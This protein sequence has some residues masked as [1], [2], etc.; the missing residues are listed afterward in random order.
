MRVRLAECDAVMLSADTAENRHRRAHS[1]KQL[2]KYGISCRVFTAFK[3]DNPRV[4]ASISIMAICH[5]ALDNGK[6]LLFFEDDITSWNP[7]DTFDVPD[8]ADVFRLGNSL[9]FTTE[10]CLLEG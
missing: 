3:S 9:A 1:L 2:D 6:P 4:S 7:C 5:E 8:D 10:A